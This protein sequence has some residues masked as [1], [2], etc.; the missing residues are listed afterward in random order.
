MQTLALARRRF[1][2][3]RRSL[4]SCCARLKFRLGA[5]LSGRASPSHGGGQWFESTSAHQPSLAGFASELRLGEPASFLVSQRAKAVSPKPRSGEGG[6]TFESNESVRSGP[7]QHQLE[8]SEVHILSPQAF[9]GTAGTATILT[10]ILRFARIHP[11]G[12]AATRMHFDGTCKKDSSTVSVRSPIRIASMLASRPTS[13]G[14]SSGTTRAGVR[15]PPST[16]PGSSW[17]PLSSAIRSLR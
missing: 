4:A 14:G 5:W 2:A 17:S 11:V 9:G 6:L 16:S 3:V 7:A 12:R 10:R 15:T 1:C 13:V 8:N